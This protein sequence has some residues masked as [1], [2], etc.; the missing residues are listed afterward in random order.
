MIR[1]FWVVDFEGEHQMERRH[2]LDVL[3]MQSERPDSDGLD[4]DSGGTEKDVEEG[5]VTKLR[6]RHKITV[7]DVAKE[8]AKLIGATGEDAEEIF[9]WS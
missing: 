5:N 7:I 3:E 9:R 6:G 4:V 2:T 1:F 8:G